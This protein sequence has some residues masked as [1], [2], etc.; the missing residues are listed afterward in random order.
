M[1][2]LFDQLFARNQGSKIF[3]SFS[4]LDKTLTYDN[5][6]NEIKCTANC[7]KQLGL[8]KGDCLVL[9]IEKSHHVFTIYGACVQLGII[10]IPLNTSYTWLEVEYFLNDSEC[11][12]FVTTSKMLKELDSFEKKGSYDIE[13]ID[14]DYKGSFFSNFNENEPLYFI[15]G[16]DED[17]TSA[18]LYTSGTTGQSKGAM[19]SQ[20]NLLSNALTLSKAWEFTASDILLHALPIYH[21]HGLFVATNIALVSGSQIRFLKK[22]D[23]DDIILNLPSTTVMMGVPTFYTRLL[24]NKKFNKEI[25]K[26]MRLFIS[27]SAPLLTETHNEFEYRTCLL[28]TSPSPRDRG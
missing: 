14:A 19:L 18:I 2:P 1:N 5:F 12:I 7:L 26:N 22:F 10:F 6:L 13:T 3:L 21:T 17:D 27:G 24:T 20:K 28:Y 4:D 25:T 16:L 23:V 9:Q 11:K 8:E 15:E